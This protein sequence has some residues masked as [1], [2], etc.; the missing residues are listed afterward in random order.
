MT[1][2]ALLREE[3]A[4]YEAQIARLRASMGKADNGVKLHRMGVINRTL[5][6][7]KGRL[8]ALENRRASA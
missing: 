7:L 2:E 3:I 6:R 5:D 8:S 1:E 4:E